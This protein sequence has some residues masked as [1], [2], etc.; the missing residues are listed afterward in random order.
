MLKIG[1]NILILLGLL[2][3]FKVDCLNDYLLIR[4]KEIQ[5]LKEVFAQRIRSKIEIDQDYQ[6]RIFE[7][8]LEKLE[9]ALVSESQY[10]LY[11]DRSPSKQIIFVCFFDKEKKEILEIGRDRVSTGNPRHKGYFLTSLKMF[12]NTIDH[13]GYRA[14][15]TKNKRGWRGLGRRNSR[16]WDFGWQETDK[17][18]QIFKIRFLMHATDPDYGESQLGKPVSRGCLRISAKLNEFLDQYGLIDRDYE[19]NKHLQKV[20]RLLRK[21]RTPVFYQGEYLI[22]GDSSKQ[23]E[24]KKEEKN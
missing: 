15:G 24:S 8:A 22:V 4:K 17:N 9:K 6:K 12:K 21:D 1:R 3:V 20:Q 10:F 7:D 16:V 19:R 14:D 18:S 11:V 23:E 13:L 5:R 2:G